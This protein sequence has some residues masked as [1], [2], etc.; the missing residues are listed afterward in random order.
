MFL[1]RISLV[2]ALFRSPPSVALAIGV[3]LVASTATAATLESAQMGIPGKTSGVSI[4]SGQSATG[5][6]F[7]VSVPFQVESIG[8]HLYSSDQQP[9][10]GAIIALDSITSL[11][12]GLPFNPNEVVASTTFIPPSPS[13][14]ILVPLSA[15]LAPGA[16][17]LLFGTNALGATGIAAVPNFPAEQ[18]DIPPTTIDS[19]ITFG[20]PRPG[21]P[22]EWRERLGSSRRF[23]VR[24]TTVGLSA[25]FDIDGDVDDSDLELWKTS[26]GTSPAAD[27]NNNGL[28][29][30]N[31]FLAWQ[32]Q[33]TGNAAGASQSVPEPATGLLG[34]FALVA[35]LLGCRK[36]R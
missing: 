16:Y 8:G 5:W 36:F 35:M 7:E 1:S 21:A 17:V 24:G 28:S 32:R 20:I 11:P 3:Y 12:Q 33:R 22:L 31:D 13:D 23:I 29:D 6:R 4:A 18:P 26:F 9:I 10:Y 30:G 34:V 14:E 27:S 15:T 25:D 2:H 19:Y